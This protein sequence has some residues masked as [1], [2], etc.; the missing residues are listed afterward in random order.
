MRRFTV[1]QITLL[2]PTASGA[3]VALAIRYMVHAASTNSK[4]TF[5]YVPRTFLMVT[6]WQQLGC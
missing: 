2:M 1:A 4:A 3:R 6:R 5:Q